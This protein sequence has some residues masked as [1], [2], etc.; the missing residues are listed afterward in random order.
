M[1]NRTT[2]AILAFFLGGFGVHRFYLGQ[3]G[4]GVLYLLFCWTFIP[5]L[6]AIIEFILFLTMS[7]DSFNSKFNK[8]FAPVQV[9]M[10]HGSVAEELGKLHELQKSGAITET[11]YA[12][13]KARILR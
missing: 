3:T 12:D 4:M 7:D 11:E 1:K 13:R 6:V 5:A 2:A 8:G 9:H 10:N